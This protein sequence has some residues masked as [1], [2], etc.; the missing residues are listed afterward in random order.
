MQSDII[1]VVMDLLQSGAARLGLAL[2]DKQL[3][4]FETYYRHLI[5]W[6]Q[7][8][9]LTTITGYDTVQ[10]RHFL[11]SLTVALAFDSLTH[12]GTRLL[13]VGA[14]A[15]FPGLPLGIAFPEIRVTLLEA[16]GK[17]VEFLRHVISALNLNNVSVING[18]AEEIAHQ[19]V[20]REQFDIVTA[21]ALAELPA[22]LEL[23]LPFCRLRGRII[24]QKKGP[25]DVE[26][27]S[28]TKALAVL[29]G[30][31]SD[32]KMVTLPEL[33]DERCLVIV[34]KVAPTPPKYPRRPGM[35]AKK[36]LI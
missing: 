25:L 15:G 26:L 31:L 8:V 6:N 12:K 34:E 30:K 29:G 18:R 32:V 33:P 17:K 2:T 35:P 24:A 13:D 3:D 36:P 14:G 7:Q 16:T 5:S 28:A 10:S 19:P 1:K 11:D 27:A 21:R 22:L 4:L 23:T 20:Y 9:N